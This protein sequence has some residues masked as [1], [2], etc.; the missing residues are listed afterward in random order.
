MNGKVILAA[1]FAAVALGMG[2]PGVAAD[3]TQGGPVGPGMMRQGAG[4]GPGPGPGMRGGADVQGQRLM[5]PCGTWQDDDDA[6]ASAADQ[7]ERGRL[8]REWMGRRH[9]GGFGGGMMGMMGGY[10]FGVG[11][12]LDRKTAMQMRG[13]MMRAMG[14]ILIKYADKIQEPATK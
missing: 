1:S 9:M 14:D 10:P 5:R 4:P 3:S 8:W 13:E 7:D 6:D 2:A 11:T 12:G